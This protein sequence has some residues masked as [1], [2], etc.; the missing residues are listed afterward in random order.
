MS[1]ARTDQGPRAKARAYLKA[2]LLAAGALPCGRC[3][4]PVTPDMAWHAGHIVDH[5][6]GGSATLANFRVEH[7]ACNTSAGGARGSR[8]TNA[9]RPAA[10]RRAASRAA[11]PDPR[12]TLPG[13]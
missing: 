11:R 12:D 5:A 13:W 10:R 1:R 3:G 6:D 8:I 2:Q 4:K 7:A 9:N